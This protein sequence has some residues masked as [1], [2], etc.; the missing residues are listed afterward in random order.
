MVSFLFS[1]KIGRYSLSA[2]SVPSHST[3]ALIYDYSWVATA[4][5]CVYMP[6]NPVKGIPGPTWVNSATAR[7]ARNG[8]SQIGGGIAVTGFHVPPQFKTNVVSGLVFHCGFCARSHFWN[9]NSQL[10]ALR[11]RRPTMI[12]PCFG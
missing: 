9:L 4:A 3:G 6:P 7:Q 11:T 5:S 1:W 10:A 2:Q 12:T 8:A